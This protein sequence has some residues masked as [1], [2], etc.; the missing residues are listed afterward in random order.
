MSPCHIIFLPGLFARGWIW[1]RVA[2]ACRLQ[3]HKITVIE[4]SIPEVFM[5]RLE[6][7]HQMIGECLN[8]NTEAGPAVLVGNSMSGLITLD[9][10]ANFP[11]LVKGVVISGAP[12]LEELDAGVSLVDLRGSVPG[13]AS[14]LCER[15]FRDINRLSK[16]DYDR[17]VSDINTIF[18]TNETFKSV[19]KWLNLSRK[20]N[21]HESLGKVQ[22]PVKLIWGDF[23]RITPAESW[24]SLASREMKLEYSEVCDCG[25]SPMLEKPD[26]FHGLLSEYLLGLTKPLAQTA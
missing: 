20:Y 7:A 3:G 19:V 12:G 15:V 21:V 6:S 13:A 25:H 11:E 24:R 16:P 9:F 8:L 18:S 26:E 2:E 10:A 1:N 14:A 5:G 4:P 23:D 17:G 22:C